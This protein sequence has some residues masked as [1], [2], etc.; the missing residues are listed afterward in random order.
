MFPIVEALT[1]QGIAVGTVLTFAIS[2]ARV[3]IPNLI[4]LN[5]LSE[6]RR[7]IYAGTVVTVNIVVGVV[8]NV[9]RI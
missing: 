5:A 1:D 8:F 3:S 2:G 6:R 7:L 9:T 4:L